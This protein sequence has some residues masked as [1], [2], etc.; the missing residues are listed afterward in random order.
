[1]EN[2]KGT[3][4]VGILAKITSRTLP[5][6]DLVIKKILRS[7]LSDLICKGINPEYYF[8]SFSG[9]NRHLSKKNIL[10]IKVAL[11]Q[12]QK[13]YKITLSGGDISGS[14]ILTVSISTFG[15]SKRP[16]I[17]RSGAKINDDIYITNNL[18]D[19]F[20]GLKVL[21]KKN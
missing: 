2:G 13:K 12:E 11:K 4:T 8:I 5:A 1:M 6:P 9:N 19:A 16:P 15:Y 18:G 17:L 21:K 7:S 3:K 10:K 20:V 14:K